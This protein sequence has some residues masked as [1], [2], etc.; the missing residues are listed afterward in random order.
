MA[1]GWFLQRESYGDEG[2]ESRFP[3][4]AGIVSGV[5]WLAVAAWLTFKYL[6]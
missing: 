6:L 5:A 2:A 1:G 3:Q 4:I